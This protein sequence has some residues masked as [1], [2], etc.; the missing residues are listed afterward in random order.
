L[1]YEK[2]ALPVFLH[3]EFE[4]AS[5]SNKLFVLKTFNYFFSNKK[6]ECE[7]IKILFAKLVKNDDHVEFAKRLFSFLKNDLRNSKIVNFDNKTQVKN[8]L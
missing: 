4:E 7:K 2:I 5:K 3:F 6:S 1:V 8:Y